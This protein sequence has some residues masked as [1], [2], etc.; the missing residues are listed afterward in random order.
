MEIVK[1]VDLG[2]PYVQTKPY[3]SHPLQS[4][5]SLQEDEG[6]G[7]EKTHS[8]LYSPWGRF[9]FGGGSH[10]KGVYNQ[11]KQQMS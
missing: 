8:I 11:L 9:V 5:P 10:M 3:K 1:L 4:K 6:S 7:H 2:V